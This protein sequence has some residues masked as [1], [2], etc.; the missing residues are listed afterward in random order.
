MTDTPNEI[1]AKAGE[2]L[3][4]ATQNRVPMGLRSSAHGVSR[5]AGGNRAESQA[6]RRVARILIADAVIVVAAILAG[7]LLHPLGIMGAFFVLLLLVAVTIS[8]AVWPNERAPEPETLRTADLKALPR[9]TERW[10][11][12]QCPALP[13]PAVPIIDR[14]GARLDQLAPQL[15]TLDAHAPAAE[16][17]RSLVAEQLPEFVRGY[18]RVPAT[19]RATPRNGKT[20]DAQL[21]DG[22]TLIERQIAEMSEQLAQ[23]DLDTLATRGRYLEIKY[24]GDEA[25]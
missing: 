5:R 24:R 3:N 12:A 16:E 14:I 19:L 13:A 21:V 7:A 9:Q 17:L 10:L 4:R 25:G 18:Q 20:P 6:S 23:G 11:A 1:M 22:L 2:V 15:A 8:L